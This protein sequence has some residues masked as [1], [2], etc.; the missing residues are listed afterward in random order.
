MIAALFATKLDPIRVEFHTPLFI[1][2][3]EPASVEKVPIDPYALVYVSEEMT[4]ELP[5]SV[6]RDTTRTLKMSVVIV[7]VLILLPISVE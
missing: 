4:M 7:V 2:M 1:F 5:L 6:D 3:V